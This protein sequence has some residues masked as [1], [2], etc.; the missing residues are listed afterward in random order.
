M[1]TIDAYRQQSGPTMIKKFLRDEKGATA[2]EYGILLVALSLTI[3]GGVEL[4]GG[5]LEALWS[6]NTSRLNQGMGMSQ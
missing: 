6:D 4:V 3:I 1:G 2:V 5:A